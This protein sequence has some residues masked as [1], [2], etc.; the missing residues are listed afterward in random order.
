MQIYLI[1]NIQIV[2]EGKI[3]TSD[4][5]IKNGRIDRIDTRITLKDI[6]YIEIN[7]EG[8]IFISGCY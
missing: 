2:N 4:V 1:K 8:Q 3:K 5:L 6:N 7:G